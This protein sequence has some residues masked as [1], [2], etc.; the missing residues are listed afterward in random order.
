MKAVV[1]FYS[2]EGNTRLIANTISEELK[3]EIVEIKP[4]R[5]I[6]SSGLKKYFWG[7][8]QV[9]LKER[10]EIEE[11]NIDFSKYDLIVFGTPVWAGRFAPVF[12]TFFN[13]YKIRDKRIALFCCHGGGKEGKT[14]IEFKE[15]LKGNEFI[16]EVDFKDPLK[17][18]SNDHILKAKE[19][20]NNII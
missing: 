5:Q 19:W 9:V 10:P 3:A 1:I 7:G 6:P 8:K 2:L 17:R 14:F 12:N 11:I 16:G 15:H 13:K 18:N 4:K 20:I